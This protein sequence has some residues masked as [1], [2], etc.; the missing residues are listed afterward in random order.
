MGGVETMLAKFNHWQ[1]LGLDAERCPI[2]DVLDKL[3]DK[4]TTLILI[5]LAVRPRRFSELRRTVPDIS[6]RMLTR[7]LRVLERDGL[8][9][10]HVFA[11][12]PPTVEYRLT[13]LGRSLLE[14]LAALV[15]WAEQSHD[16]VR[17]ARSRYDAALEELGWP[18][19]AAS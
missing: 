17:Q 13:D 10:R 16:G 1:T 4:W 15:S 14:P 19:H 12:K 8:V 11:T 2:R 9:T 18:H 3:G 6:K 7:A 5:A